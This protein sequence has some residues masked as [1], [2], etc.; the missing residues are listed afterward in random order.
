MLTYYTLIIWVQCVCHFNFRTCLKVF[1][2]KWCQSNI[3][4]ISQLHVITCNQR[5]DLSLHNMY[6]QLV[7]HL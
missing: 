2:E 5:H 3:I 4:I 1:F 6:A 7:Q